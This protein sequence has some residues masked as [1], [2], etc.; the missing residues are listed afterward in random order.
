LARDECERCR[1]EQRSAIHWTLPNKDL[2][3]NRLEAVSA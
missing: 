2:F 1:C 3:R